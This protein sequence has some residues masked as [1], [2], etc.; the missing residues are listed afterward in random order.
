MAA[1]ILESTATATATPAANAAASD[2]ADSAGGSNGG[3]SGGG[4][5]S[6]RRAWIIGS[7]WSE[8]DWGGQLPDRSWVDEVRGCTMQFGRLCPIAREA[9][10]WHE[11]A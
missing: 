5:I 6:D 11:P 9:H 3:G 10:I 1:R 8:S 2:A 7:G 4:S